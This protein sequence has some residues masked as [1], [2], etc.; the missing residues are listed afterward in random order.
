MFNHPFSKLF[1]CC[2]LL[3]LSITNVLH[4][5]FAELQQDFLDAN[6][7]NVMVTAHRADWRNHPENSLPAIQSCIDN[8]VQILEL[9]IRKTSDGVMVLMHDSTV[10]RTTNGSG[11]VANMTLAQIKALRLIHNGVVTTD[12]VPTLAEAMLL[13]K[14]HCFVYLDKVYPSWIAETMAVLQDTDTVD[15]GLWRADAAAQTVK[16]DFL[17]HG[18]DPSTIHIAFKVTCSGTTSPTVETI[19][20]EVDILDPAVLQI[21]YNDAG[22]PIFDAA[23]IA[24]LKTVGTRPFVNTMHD[25]RV[26]EDPNPGAE[27]TDWDWVVDHGITVIQTD[28]PL[29][30][31]D[32]VSR[33]VFDASPEHGSTNVLTGVAFS[34]MRGYAATSHDVYL[35]KDE[36]AVSGATQASAEFRGNQAGYTYTPSEPLDGAT[37]YYWRVDEVT[38]DGTVVG[39]V[40]SLTTAAPLT[41]VSSDLPVSA[42]LVLHLDAGNM[43]HLA[44]MD[45]VSLWQDGSGED[46]HA[47]Q[48]TRGLDLPV[49]LTAGINGQPAVRF[50]G[51]N[52]SMRVN[53]ATP[54]PVNSITLF[55][56]AAGSGKY[57][58]T[59]QDASSMDN[60]LRLSTYPD[61]LSCRVGSDS[62]V[63][64]SP[65]IAVDSD[66]HVRAVVSGSSSYEMYHDGVLR[67]TDSQ[68]SSQT[69]KGI[70]LAAYWDA[71]NAVKE[72]SSYDIAEV[73]VYDRALT[74][75]EIDLVNLHLQA[76]YG[77]TRDSSV[78]NVRVMLV[79]GQS[80]AD[81]RAAISE[82]PTSPVDLQS[83]QDDVDFFYKIEG[84][85]PSLT[86]LRPGLSESSQ[87]GPSVTLGRALADLYA[88]ETNTRVAMIKYANGGTN[89]HTQ[90]KAG[91]DPTLTGDGAE[92]VT[93][94]QTVSQGLVS[95]AAL[96]PNADLD[97]EG[98]VWMQGE[99]DATATDALSYQTN[100]TDFISDIRLT[101][102]EN[103]P[104]VIGRLSINQTN[105]NATYLGQIRAAQDAVEAADPRTGIIDTDSF[106]LNADQLHFSG[107]GQQAM[108]AA[109]AESSAYYSWMQREFTSAEIDAGDA[110]PDAD[111]DGDGKINDAEFLGDSAPKDTTSHF[112]AWITLPSQDTAQISYASSSSRKYAIEQYEVATGEWIEI[113]P[114]EMGHGGVKDRALVLVSTPE[115][116]RVR[117]DLP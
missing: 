69:V 117:C 70:N 52:D 63:Y 74:R 59:T 60:R 104:F 3:F 66:P 54:I 9:D 72:W 77:G 92:Y 25:G 19:M 114:Y 109:F 76:K 75:S 101:Y 91:G 115:I 44:N 6:S 88:G 11:T 86:T 71:A 107:A 64:G 96:Y 30:L 110:E 82:L 17:A 27:P 45:D 58:V 78:S 32:H 1:S 42:G 105:L 46:N 26:H 113:L 8:G 40:L 61:Q 49:Y 15:N 73:V 99:S 7:D 80:N 35:G 93:F 18:I 20:S 84:G 97:L 112:K 55:T 10:N 34:W 38:P 94:Q 36:G 5:G 21:N 4:A 48:G 28:R 102:G 85:L 111:P 51:S 103:L 41:P 50:D 90:W 89:L 57:V 62:Y 83:P 67:V 29:W 33:R 23:N 24:A 31:V 53:L 39:E 108:G 12:Q 56:V 95:L 68:G 13:S 37:T 47:T 65:A 2:F 116:F 100:L 81:G 22:H 98:M 16:N 43:S 106:G 79:G 87:F 14:D